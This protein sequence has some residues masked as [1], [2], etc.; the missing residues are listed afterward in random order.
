MGHKYPY[1]CSDIHIRAK[2]EA[3]PATR[4]ASGCGGRGWG[5]AHTQ[6]VSKSLCKEPRGSWPFSL[7]H[8]CLRSGGDGSRKADAS[9]PGL[10]AQEAPILCHTHILVVS[11]ALHTAPRVTVQSYKM[12][13]T[14]LVDKRPAGSSE[15]GSGRP[16]AP[17]ALPASSGPHRPA[18]LPQA[19]HL[20]S[21]HLTGRRSAYLASVSLPVKWGCEHVQG[22]A[23]PRAATRGRPPPLRRPRPEIAG[24]R[25]FSSPA[26]VQLLLSTPSYSV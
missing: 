23:V 20:G 25:L 13:L 22:G 12:G 14:L 6:A 7:T 2:R 5:R 16:S 8:R 18:T 17:A 4:A 21:S 11:C 26:R 10:R 3:G 9:G 15:R 24:T 19:L 1:L